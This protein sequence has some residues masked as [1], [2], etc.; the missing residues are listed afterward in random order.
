MRFH[1]PIPTTGDKGLPKKISDVHGALLAMQLVGPNARASSS[2]REAWES[3]W[4]AKETGSAVDVERAASAV[5][6]MLRAQKC[7]APARR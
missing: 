2:W 3:L 5:E 7:L 4:T 1:E 6:A